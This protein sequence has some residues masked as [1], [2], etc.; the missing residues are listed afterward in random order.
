MTE[1]EAPERIEIHD[2]I[3]LRTA[4]YDAPPVNGAYVRADRY[5]EAL[6]ALREMWVDV[7][8]EHGF[9]HFEETFPRAAKI[10]ARTTGGEG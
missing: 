7:I 5:D 9:A 3:A 10:R 8:A 2:G 1:R 4:D 6:A